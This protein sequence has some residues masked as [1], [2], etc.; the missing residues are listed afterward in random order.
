MTAPSP[1]ETLLSLLTAHS[2]EL[3]AGATVPGADAELARLGIDS[4]ELLSL[5]VDLEAAFDLDID[6]A[7]LGSAKTITDLLTIVDPAQPKG[8]A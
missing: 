6:D 2:P 5:A 3:R 8:R 7:A 1:L 4:L